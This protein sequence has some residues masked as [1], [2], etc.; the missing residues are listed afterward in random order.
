MYK[1]NDTSLINEWSLKLYFHFQCVFTKFP[2]FY[3]KTNAYLDFPAILTPVSPVDIRLP[4]SSLYV[5]VCK[6]VAIFRCFLGIIS[7]HF[8][9]YFTFLKKEKKKIYQRRIIKD[10]VCRRG[11]SFMILSKY[12]CKEYH[13]FRIC[14]ERGSRYFH[15]RSDL[16]DRNRYLIVGGRTT[17]WRLFHLSSNQA[18]WV[19]LFYCHCTSEDHWLDYYL[20][21]VSNS[22]QWY[23]E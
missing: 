17:N 20:W 13:I 9:Y 15:I 8:P 3:E 2:P 10:F 21:V 4:K 14:D 22:K 23:L 19:W 1:Q 11:S 6:H 12:F 18:W 5:Q 7:A 16:L